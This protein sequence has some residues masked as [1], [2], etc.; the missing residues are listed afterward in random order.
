M[1]THYKSLQ[2]WHRSI[3]NE[4]TNLDEYSESLIKLACDTYVRHLICDHILDCTKLSF[5]E[6]DAQG[7]KKATKARV[8]A[9][10]KKAEQH[11]ISLVKATLASENTAILKRKAA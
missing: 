6:I 10:L 1:N 8:A 4:T 3:K 9:R 11:I 2:E 5:Q 7:S